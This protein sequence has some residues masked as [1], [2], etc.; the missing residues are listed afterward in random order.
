METFWIVFGFVA[1]AVFCSAFVVQW[2]VSERLKRSHVP[3][4]FWYLRIV[5]SAMLL[6][7]SVSM[8]THGDTKA[9]PL[10]FG[11]ALNGVIYVRN[12]ML[13][14]RRPPVAVPGPAQGGD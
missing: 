10:V 6:I 2:W 3:T 11:F 4:S 5:G 8:L 7:L 13:I 9:I 14:H 12:L 1:Q